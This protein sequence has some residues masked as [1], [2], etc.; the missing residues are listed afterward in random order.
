MYLFDRRQAMAAMLRAPFRVA[1]LTHCKDFLRVTWCDGAKSKFPNIWL[2]SS[3][4]DPNFFEDKT[5]TYHSQLN[6]ARFIAE[7]SPIVGAEHID[8]SEDITVG[9]EDHRSAF[10][11]SWLR[12]RDTSNGQ[13]L[14]KEHDIPLWDASSKSLIN[15]YKYAERKEKLESWMTDLK[16]CGLVYFQGVPPTKEGLN[17]VLNSIGQTMQRHHP[18]NVLDINLDLVFSK[19][20]DNNTYGNH[21]HPVHTDN[22]FYPAPARL[23]CLLCTEYSAPVQDTVNFFVDSLKIIDDIRQEEPEAYDL[24]RNNPVRLARRR[25]TVQEECAP[26]DVYIYNYETMLKKELIQYDNNE[27]RLMLC[28]SNYQSGVDLDSFKDQR[29]LKR[30]YEAFLFLQSK[31]IDPKYQQEVVLKKGCA[32]VFNNYRVAHGRGGID[33]SS[34]RS[35]VLAFVADSMWRTRWR[36]MLGDKSGLDSKWLYACTEQ[37]LEILAQR[38]E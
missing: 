15:T 36:I 19:N 32:A 34:K 1:N 17:G 23:V 18:T 20:I 2:R 10:N 22:S 13:S 35:L 12:A 38:K 7:E 3:V 37:E 8:G 14:I 16:Q 9:W 6:Y 29:D 33:P 30:Y 24:L 4:R 25:L 21:P 28:F 27:R 31:L 5:C 11:A 26:E